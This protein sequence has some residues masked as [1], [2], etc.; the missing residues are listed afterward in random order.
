MLATVGVAARAAAELRSA[1][2]RAMVDKGNGTMRTIDGTS[3]NL[4]DTGEAYSARFF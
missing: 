4:P 1:P 3:I 2:V